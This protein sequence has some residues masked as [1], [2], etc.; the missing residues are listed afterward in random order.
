MLSSGARIA[1]E[2]A[3]GWNRQLRISPL[4][5]RAYLRA[6]VLTAYMMALLTILVLYASGAALGVRCRLGS[7]C[8]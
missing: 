4:S 7:G 5:T 6:K 1:A 2:R 8:R 3:V